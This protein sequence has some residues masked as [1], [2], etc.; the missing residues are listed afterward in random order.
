V[1]PP[2][3]EPPLFEVPPV[4]PL[5]ALAVLL[6]PLVDPDPLPVRLPLLPVLVP[7][8]ARPV[9]PPE[10]AP[11]AEMA[12]QSCFGPHMKPWPHES[13]ELHVSPV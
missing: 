8:V 5:E 1:L 9:E 12:M 3:E 4:L 10:E 2:L 11:P 6:A 13:L 7:P